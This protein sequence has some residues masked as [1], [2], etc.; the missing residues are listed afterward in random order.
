MKGEKTIAILELEKGT[1]DYH[2]MGSWDIDIKVLNC[3]LR[4]T[5][6]EKLLKFIEAIHNNKVT[7][8]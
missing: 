3:A 5:A 7:V 4:E 8:E 2:V 6:R 1:M